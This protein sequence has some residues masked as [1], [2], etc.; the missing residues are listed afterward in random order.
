MTRN[1]GNNNGVLGWEKLSRAPEVQSEKPRPGPWS[2]LED[3]AKEMGLGG[4]QVKD[5]LR[6]GE[7]ER[8]N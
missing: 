3:T 7:T 6:E 2:L 5:S 1:H 4:E 8:I